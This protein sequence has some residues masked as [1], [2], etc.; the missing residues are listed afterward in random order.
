MRFQE[1]PLRKRS[2]TMWEIPQSGGMRVPG[3]VFATERMMGEIVKDEAI[4]QV[5]NVA[6]LPGIRKYSIGMPDIHWG[7]GVITSY[8]I[9]YTKLYDIP[10]L[11]FRMPGRWATFIT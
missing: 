4:R 5:M 3:L 9:H 11:Y 7:Y 1:V 8:S 2:D 6:H 10:M